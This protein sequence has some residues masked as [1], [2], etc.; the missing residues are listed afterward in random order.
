[1]K[2]FN[3][4]PK[5]RLTSLL[6]FD[7]AFLAQK[8]ALKPC[9]KPVS[10][11]ADL[12]ARVVFSVQLANYQFDTPLILAPMAGVSDRPF[13]LLCRKLGADMA[14]GE[15]ISSRP[16]LRDSEK[17]RRRCDHQGET[18]LRSVQILGNEPHEM[19]QSARYNFE[20]GAQ[21]ID[22]NMGCPAKKV[23]NKAAGSALLRE[24]ELVQRI[25]K[26]VVAA[27]PIPVTLKI[28][29]GWSPEQRNGPDIAKM[30][31]DCGIQALTV[32]G[33]TRACR[34][35]GMAEYDTIAEIKRQVS[36]PVIAN[37]DIDSPQKA[38]KVLAWTQADALMVGRAAQGRPWIFNQIRHY[39][40]T[41]QL[42]A[43][44]SAAQTR[45]ILLG[46]VSQLYQFYG[47]FMGLRIAR[48]HVAWYCQHQ[49]D[50]VQFRSE[51][52]RHECPQ[53]QQDSIEQYFYQLEQRDI[54]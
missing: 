12:K 23:C 2:I 24:P 15:M 39:L 36:I 4:L 38:A 20:A 21:V 54:L 27:V 5:Q 31:Q 29:T 45:Q 41:G 42:Q 8:S 49:P 53:A 9:C 43:A 11:A 22:I 44:P 13:R 28:R 33:R 3:R 25:L 18:G 35:E 50:A 14:V 17:S 47:E 10:L 30:A 7:C 46:H 48:K 34:F 52:N 6:H 32:H 1:M 19:A 37:G 51:F 16:E 26:A 40:T